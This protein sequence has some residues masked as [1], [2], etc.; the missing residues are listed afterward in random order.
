[1]QRRR[2]WPSRAFARRG[3]V[4]DVAAAGTAD[5][6]SPATIIPPEGELAGFHE[7]APA[8]AVRLAYRVI[9][10]R[11]P[12]PDGLAH[13]VALLEA[14]T[15]SR[16][17]LLVAF[18]NSDERHLEIDILRGAGSGDGPRVAP[19]ALWPSFA[20]PGY[21]GQLRDEFQ[22]TLARERTGLR[23]EDC[24]FYHSIDLPGGEPI[25]GPW[26]LRGREQLYLG[27]V[28]LAGKRVLEMGPASGYLSFWME[29]Q[30]AEVV[31]MDCGFDRSI[32]LLPVPTLHADT[33]RL[34]SDHG[35][36][37]GAFQH[38]FWYCHQRLQSK[39]KMV[40]G[41]V[42]DLPGDLGEFDVA[43]FGAILLHMRSPI[44][45]LEQAARRTRKTIVVTESWTGGEGSMMENIMRPF[46]MGVE[47]RWVIWWEVS[48]G[49]VV[50]MLE[51]L[52]FTDTT[53]ITH[54]QRH[55]HGH[56][57]SAAYVETPMF[58]VVGER[59]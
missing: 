25:D 2:P 24:R 15:M 14:G 50:S 33:R 5:P 27:N 38:A 28:S 17:E 36:M 8:D 59:P 44:S 18:R 9:L 26:D 30:G 11:E 6:I 19:V 49:A 46:P 39:V 31:G 41:D 34:R 42:Y 48:A 35:R 7:L 51:V 29:H 37:V 12:D 16:D 43:T 45:A 58:T 32:D 21:L 56:D 52:G 22:Q 53:V 55:Q 3:A 20:P 13:Y 57:E 40:Y 47:G 1:M 10:E 4:D 23:K 54:T